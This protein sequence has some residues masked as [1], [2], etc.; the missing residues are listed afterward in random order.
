MKYTFQKDFPQLAKDFISKILMKNSNQRSKISQ[1]R[2]HPW[3][4]GIFSRKLNLYEFFFKK[5]LI[6]NCSSQARNMRRN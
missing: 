3:I 2:E 4:T 6:K 5:M 1:M